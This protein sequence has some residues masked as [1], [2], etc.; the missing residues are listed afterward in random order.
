MKLTNSILKDIRESVG[1][2][3]DVDSFDTELLMHVNA[4]IS[5]LN[6][7]GVGKLITVSDV[8]TTWEDLIDTTQVDGNVH[9]KLVPLYM[10]LATK[11]IF[12]PPPPSTVEYY[13]RTV[14]ELL[15]RLKLAYEIPINTGG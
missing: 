5:R 10:T 15:W 9:F 1:L 12:D 11:I 7:N 3:P 8:E 2:G 14:D 4:H 13:S 6:Q